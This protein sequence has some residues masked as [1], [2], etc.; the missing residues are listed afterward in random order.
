VHIKNSGV[1]CK[2]GAGVG[3]RASRTRNR[4]GYGVSR[5]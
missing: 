2:R 4:W 5:W 3:G 1:E